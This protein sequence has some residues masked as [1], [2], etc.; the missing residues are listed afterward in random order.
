MLNSN[1][2]KALVAKLQKQTSMKGISKQM[3]LKYP[4]IVFMQECAV[5]KLIGIK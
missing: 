1:I 2:D 5:Q 3:S 4:T